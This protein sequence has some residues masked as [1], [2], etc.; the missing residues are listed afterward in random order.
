MTSPTVVVIDSGVDPS[1]P[2]LRGHAEVIAGP[3]FDG[4]GVLA[5]GAGATD[6]L[7]H[8]SAVAATIASFVDAVTIVSLKVFERDPVCDFRAVL[9]ALEHALSYDAVCIN[10]SLGTTS[11]RFRGQLEELAEAANA[12]A[13]R[14]VASASYGGLPC[15]PGSIAGF[16]GV[17]ADPNVP[18]STPELR[19][20]DGG[21][22][23]FAS[24]LPPPDAGGGRTLQARGDS[25][26]CAAVSGLL[27]RQTCS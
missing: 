16:E 12:R 27:V 25:L 2:A 22:I 1:H 9:H 17:V 26:A 10:L 3:A 5:E 4:D 11:L 13:V 21:W 7:G 20:H 8:G 19:P 14:I 15:D 24:P 6:L 18:R 23:W